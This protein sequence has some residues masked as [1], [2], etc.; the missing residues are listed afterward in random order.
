M[1]GACAFP[2][3]SSISSLLPLIGV[4]MSAPSTGGCRPLSL[5]LPERRLGPRIGK[6]PRCR[7][8]RHT[9]PE[10]EPSRHQEM[11]DFR[12]TSY[13]REATNKTPPNMSVS[14]K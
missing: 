7:P 12:G 9:E 11:R 4:R 2:S 14:A 6:S 13:A 3:S 1:L 8:R 10:I 5:A